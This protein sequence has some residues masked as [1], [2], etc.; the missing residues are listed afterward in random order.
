MLL[1]HWLSRVLFRLGF[2]IPRGRVRLR[3]RDMRIGLE[4]LEDRIAPAAFVVTNTDNSGDGSLRQAISD[5]NSVTGPDIITFSIPGGGVQTITPTFLLPEITESVIIDATTQPGWT[6][7]TPMIELD[8]ELAG[9]CNGLDFSVG[10]NTVRGL[11]INSFKF[12]GIVL[13]EPGAPIPAGGNTIQD[14][15]LGTNATGTAFKPNRTGLHVIGSPNNVIDGNVISGNAGDGIEIDFAASRGNRLTGNYIGTDV[16]G[17]HPLGNGANGVSLVAPNVLFLR[18]GNDD[19]QGYASGNFIDGSVQ[20]NVISGNKQS[21]IYIFRGSDNVVEGNF[22]G[23]A[24]DG[25]TALPN[26]TTD[27]AALFGNNGVWI[28]EGSGNIIGRPPGNHGNVISSNTGDGIRIS[29]VRNSARNNLVQFNLIGTDFDGNLK[30]GLGN[31]LSGVDIRNESLDGDTNVEVSGNRIGGTDADD[32]AVDGTNSSGN[33]ISGNQG[34]GVHIVGHRLRS[35]IIQG[36]RIGTDFAGT[37]QAA[38]EGDGINLNSFNNQ[39]KGDSF[40]LIGGMGPLAG[41]TIS[42]NG[43]NGIF[44]GAGTSAN[45]AQN[46]IGTNSAANAPLGNTGHGIV[47]SGSSNNVIGGVR[48]TGSALDLGGNVIASNKSSGL[49]ILS[50]S[51]DNDVVGNLIGTNQDGDALGNSQDGVLIESAHNNTIGGFQQ[52]LANAIKFN[53]LNGV[54]IRGEN[55][56][57][58]KVQHS[59]IESNG[60]VGIVSDEGASNTVIDSVLSSGNGVGGIAIVKNA[61][62][63]LTNN[64]IGTIDAGNEANPNAVYGVFIENSSFTLVGGD[65]FDHGGNLISGNT[66]VGIVVTGSETVDTIIKGNYIGTDITGKERLGNGI[67]INITG[68]PDIGH[69]SR[70]TVSGNIIAGNEESGVTILNGASDNIVAGNFIGTNSENTDLGHGAG[71]GILI[72]NSPDNTIGGTEAESA[73]YINFNGDGVE[74]SNENATGNKILRNFILDN[75]TSGVTVQFTSDTTIS[76]N[77]LSGNARGI[78]ILKT[79]GTTIRDN[80][81]GTTVDGMTAQPNTQV[82]IIIDSSPGTV[83]GGT[84]YDDGGNLISGNGGAGI[85]VRGSESVNVA[86]TGNRIGTNGAGTQPLGNTLDGIVIFA[87]PSF[88]G[89]PSKL[90][91]SNNFIAANKNNGITIKDGAFN[92]MIGGATEAAGNR[93]QQ[94][95]GAGIALEATAGTGNAI[96]SNIIFRNGDLGIDLGATGVTPNDGRKDTDSGPN[97]LQNFPELAIATIGASHRIAGTLQSTAS[98]V[99]QIQIFANDPAD[100]SGFGEGETLETTTTVATNASGVGFFEV[101]LPNLSAGAILTATATDANNNTSEFSKSLK[102]ETDTDGDGIP[103][104]LESAAPN[105]GDGNQDG[106]ADSTQ[107]TVASFPSTSNSAYVTLEL[108]SRLRNIPAP[109]GASFQKVRPLVNPSPDDAPAGNFFGLNFFDFTVTGVAAGAPVVVDVTLPNG[110]TPRSYFRYGPLSGGTGPVWYNWGFDGTTGVEISANHATLHF[111]DGQRGDDDLVAN[112]KIVDPGAPGLDPPLLVTN[113]LDSGPGSLRQAILDANNHPGADTIDFQ[114]GSGVQTII[115]LTALPNITDTVT[116]DGTSQPGFVD[117]PIIELSGESVPGGIGLFVN[118][119]NSVVRGLVINRWTGSGI[120]LFDNSVVLEGSFIGTDVTGMLA[121]PNGNGIVVG[122]ASDIRIGGTTP[123]QRNVISGNTGNG[124]FL[125]NGFSPQILG[126]FIGVAADGTSALGNRKNGIGAQENVRDLTI[127]GLTDGAG[128]VIAFN[129]QNG[130]A[131][132]ATNRGIAIYSNSIYSNGLQGISRTLTPDL[133]VLNDIG[134][135]DGF[136]TNVQNFPVLFSAQSDAGQTTIQGYL[137]SRSDQSFTVQFFSNTSVEVSGFGEGQTFLGTATITTDGD[138]HAD[139]NVTL[140]VVIGNART[141]TATATSADNNTSE[142]SR[143]VGVGEVITNIIVVNSSDDLDD[144][145]ADATHTSLREAIHA[146]N[147]SPGPDE[148]RFAIGSG[149]QTINLLSPLPAILDTVTIDGT[150]QP[151][152]AGSPIIEINGASLT[153]AASG[154]AINASDTVVRGLVINGFGGAGIDV[155][156]IGTATNFSGVVIE[157]NFIGTDVTGMAARPNLGGIIVE[158]GNNHRIGGTT[159]LQRNVIS[160]NTAP[161]FVPDTH[162]GIDIINGDG[163]VIQGNYIGVAADGVSPLGNALNGIGVNIRGTGVVTHLMIGG[164]AAGAGNEIAFNGQHGIQT[165]SP[166]SGNAILSNSIYSNFLLGIAFN[167]ENVVIP[168]ERPTGGIAIKYPVISSAESAGGET[169]ISG[170]L[171]SLPNATYRLEFFSST[172]VDPSGFGEGEVFIGSSS[173]TT[174]AVGHV[175]FSA[176]LPVPVADRRLITATATDAANNTSQFS[177]RQAVGEEHTGVFIVNT[178]DDVDDG[179]A[180]ATH[181]SLREAILA[182]NNHPGPDEIRFAIGSGVQTISPLTPLPAIVDPVVIDGWTQ[183]GFDGTPMI[184]ISGA[185]MERQRVNN[186]SATEFYMYGINVMADNTTVR[187]LVINRFFE[188]LIDPIFN[189]VLRSGGNPLSVTG[190]NNVIEGN[191]VGTNVAGTSALGDLDAVRITGSNNRIGGATAQQRNLFD[192]AHDFGLIVAGDS[193]TLQ[194]NYVGVSA[195]GTAAIPNGRG[196]SFGGLAVRVTGVNNVIGGGTPGA[197]N[198]ISGNLGDALVVEGPGAVIQGNKIGT[199][200]AGTALLRNQGIGLN[201]QRTLQQIIFGP[202]ESHDIVGGTQPG[203]GNVISGNS[204]GINLNGVEDVIQGNFIGTDITG[205]VDLGNSSDGMEVFGDRELI[206]G[207]EPDAGNIISGNDHFGIVVIFNGA[208]GHNL[209]QGNRIGTKADG[210]TALGNGSD[211][212]AFGSDSLAGTNGTGPTDDV[213]GGT[214]AGAG[215][216]IAFNGGNGVNIAAGLHIGILSNSIFSN[217]RLGIDLNADGATANDSGDVDSGDNK[218]QNFPVLSAAATDGSKTTVSGTLNSTPSAVFLVQ[219]FANAAADPSGFG[220]GQ[221]LLGS[222]YV[223]TDDSGNGPFT[224]VFP[225]AVPIGQLVTAT[226]TDLKNNTSEFSLSLE[227]SDGTIP[228]NRPPLSDAGGPYTIKE[229]DPL[230]LFSLSD[231][232]DG[233]SITISWDINGDGVFGDATD[234]APVFTWAQL[235]ALGIVNGPSSFDVRVRVDDGQ[236]HVVT[237][238]ATTLNV[239]NVKPVVN[240]GP[241]TRTVAEGT[242]IDFTG[243]FTDPGTADTHTLLWHVTASNGQVIADGSDANFSFVPRDNGIYTV[244][245]TVTDSDQESGS[246]VVTV[247]VSNAKPIPLV[248]GLPVQGTVGVPIHLTSSVSDPS[249]VDEAAGLLLTWFADLTPDYELEFTATTADFTFTP[250]EPGIWDI[251][252][253]A[254]DK[255]QGRGVFDVFL[256]VLPDGTGSSP[257]VTLAPDASIDEGSNYSSSGS[258]ADSDVDETWTATVDY[259]DGSGEQPLTLNADKTFTL[260]HLYIDNGIF[261]VVVAVTDSTDRSGSQTTHVTVENAAPEVIAAADQS[262]TA[263]TSQNFQLGSFSDAGT[264]DADWTVNV[265][266]GDGSAHT[267]FAVSTPGAL[268]AKPHIYTEAVTF[269][270]TLSV[271]DKDGQSGV[272]SYHINVSEV[273]NQAPVFTSTAEFSVAENSTS[274]GTVTATDADLPAQQIAFSISGG[275]DAAHFVISNSGVLTFATPPDFEQP[276]DTGSDNV[277][278]LQV[279]ADDGHGGLTAQDI[280][281]TVTDVDEGLQP[282]HLDLGGPD[283]TYLKKQP[284]ITVLPQIVVSGTTPLEGGSL[285]LSLNLAGGKK[286][287]L[288]RVIAS[289]PSQLG[290]TTGP[291][292]ANRQLTLTIQLNAAATNASIQAFLRGITFATKGKGLKTPTRSLTITLTADNGTPSTVTQTIHVRKKA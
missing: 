201:L 101:E 227:V 121:R 282:P 31:G 102:V 202:A 80:L 133:V 88:G 246:A 200:A 40:T 45:V 284:P 149:V 180:D 129:V 119:R 245:F 53:V 115:P 250:T 225:V 130:V 108:G 192:A 51:G 47:L 266:W 167:L 12:D 104:S 148:I 123:E 270:V 263:G 272:A 106:I 274:V 11:V 18:N 273:G 94:N 46:K 211:G 158:N 52:E 235:Q 181:T 86:I 244:T 13:I 275:P 25:R 3:R 124:V 292:V 173:V 286:K 265:D 54:E 8:G 57:D 256:E 257:I 15:F 252:L 239:L 81:I 184:E 7:R 22:V 197:G 43:G 221:L 269:T 166:L 68:R 157:G 59:F 236:G 139:F 103:D 26:G 289:D 58:N 132:L 185:Q 138:G 87:S 98:T 220:E 150:T 228:G 195:D 55:A 198:V 247:T 141:I 261:D 156:D 16:T 196:V 144:G 118:A 6:P 189:A 120:N 37:A 203:Q 215:N 134:T 143:R 288:D 111:V 20:T 188:L 191:Y 73:N 154:L 170:Y 182:A 249:S 210:T 164:T 207:T 82:G 5:A 23:V 48:T 213:V 67:G 205:T 32:G 61:N 179:T 204:I 29:A 254:K 28:E 176:V 69:A 24:A 290:S 216:I 85:Q 93:I 230:N 35:N 117:K 283:V 234:A 78:G 36:N 162:S 60:Q 91:I 153:T 231:D 92:N 135:S 10:G 190:D 222:H 280:T 151:G 146:A 79:G 62:A 277:Y 105:G 137:N 260:A 271:T 56:K 165:R 240:A 208:S 39:T 218:L 14:C 74:I 1:D 287:I 253:I 194:G 42:A 255:D 174:D 226:A 19:P 279:T 17:M 193:N 159:A 122:G 66:A 259:G 114:I 251:A 183:P 147:N 268:P 131:D 142:F 109:A 209:I 77:Q 63:I 41:N 99:F 9:D 128:N 96:L 238:S 212:V 49:A 262:A 33:T 199:N 126:N 155:I 84:S 219:V 70:T 224:F 217:G 241:A 83:I 276:A 278:H 171:N 44:I 90:T 232:Y 177:R 243:T 267:T 186:P 95:F 187:G 168:N 169:T 206:G 72:D 125:N 127:G 291:Q 242:Q 110:V 4:Y 136:G 116:I 89:A 112:G 50:G 237:S 34:D 76:G 64:T 75:H 113:T 65:D 163:D 258:F 97:N 145:I 264:S 140:P 178:T 2:D 30:A 27:A 175:E 223:T 152:F 233:D 21:G 71:A 229:G 248:F 38:N 214:D 100:P 172:A 107:A 281:V 161:A 160:G 285:Q